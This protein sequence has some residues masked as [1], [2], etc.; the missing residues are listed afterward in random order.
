MSYQVGL[1]S[2]YGVVVVGCA[3]APH[4]HVRLDSDA[5][6]FPPSLE[7]GNSL[8]GARWVQSK[9]KISLNR[10]FLFLNFLNL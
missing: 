5:P 6:I 10:L 2:E 4:S 1:E 9:S 3:A 8:R 7:A